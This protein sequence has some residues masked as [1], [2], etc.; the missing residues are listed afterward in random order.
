[1]NSISQK[2]DYY[3]L[4]SLL[5]QSQIIHTVGVRVFLT[6]GSRTDEN[7]LVKEDWEEAGKAELQ[8]RPGH[9]SEN[10]P[11]WDQWWRRRE[12]MRTQDLKHGKHYRLDTSNKYNKISSNNTSEGILDP[13]V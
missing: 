13:K 12:H 2:Y 5:R 10:E 4:T 8:V 1:M 7:M 3:Y 9:L 11:R 6:V